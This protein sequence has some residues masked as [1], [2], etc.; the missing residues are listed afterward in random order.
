[1]LKYFVNTNIIDV[2]I[3]GIGVLFA[4]TIFIILF[5]RINSLK[6]P[7]HQNEQ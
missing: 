4:V 6:L 3:I 1:M 7:E 2:L 5:V